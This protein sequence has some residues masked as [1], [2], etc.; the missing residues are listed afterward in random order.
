MRNRQRYGPEILLNFTREN[1]R[2]RTVQDG[3]ETAVGLGEEGCFHQARV[4]FEGDELHG[5]G[6]FGVDHFS[7]DQETGDTHPAAH[8]AGQSIYLENIFIRVDMG[9]EGHGVA[10]TSL[11]RIKAIVDKFTIYPPLLASP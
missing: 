2:S 10:V 11:G 7:G 8:E 3:A 1:K 6:V 5:F 9:K 4:I